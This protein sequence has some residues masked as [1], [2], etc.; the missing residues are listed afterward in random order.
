MRRAMITR[1]RKKMPE[2]AVVTGGSV[3]L[4]VPPLLH[5]P[6][7]ATGSYSPATRPASRLSAKR[8]AAPV[9][10]SWEFRPMWQTL[11]GSSTRQIATQTTPPWVALVVGRSLRRQEGI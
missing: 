6:A 11:H 8:F 9:V 7:T 3:G 1:G 10:T 2:I 5:W 4:G